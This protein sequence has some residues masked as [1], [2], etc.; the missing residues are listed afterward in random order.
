MQLRDLLTQLWRA[1][2]PMLAFLMVL[3]LANILLYLLLEQSL[4][5][6]VETSESRFIKRQTEVR[7]LL[8]NQGGGDS[9]EQQYILASQDLSEFRQAV[10]GYVEFTGLIEELMELS[11]LAGL[12]ISQIAYK[13]EQAGESGLLR[14]A[15]TFNVGGRYEQLKRFI[16]AMEQSPR[17]LIIS[18]I[19]LQ[20]SDEGGVSLRL[21]LET[22]FRVE[23]NPA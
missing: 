15:L 10:P 20:S 17:L 1:N 21:S 12:E 14:Y 9:P 11:S 8:H 6:K 3:L 5:P 2:R 19:G 18:G 23:A 22:Y 7:Q 13:P 4:L 16:H